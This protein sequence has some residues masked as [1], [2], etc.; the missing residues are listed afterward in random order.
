MNDKERSLR[1]AETPI[2]D[3][4]PDFPGILA[5]MK[6]CPEI[7]TH[8]RGLADALLVHQFPDSTLTRAERELL[9]TVTS[10]N[11]ECFYCMDTHS[12]FA[13]ELLRRENVS[14]VEVGVI[15]DSI[16]LGNLEQTTR[17][18]IALSVIARQVAK[19]SRLLTR[20]DIEHALNVGASNGDIQ[21]TIL[22]ASAFCMY[23]RMVDGLRAKTP[24]NITAY[25]ARARE[26]ADHGY[27]DPRTVSI[28]T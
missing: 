22:I 17:K 3:G 6:L 7:E 11:N 23:N 9:A 26:I 28:P 18:F 24:A 21:L 8:L 16:K 1:A 27:S 25:E 2:V 19:N 14:N 15:V 5:A 12:A 13:L 4:L 20:Q 10:A